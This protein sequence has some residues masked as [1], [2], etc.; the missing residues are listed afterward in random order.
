MTGVASAA[1]ALLLMASPCATQDE[2]Q[3]RSDCRLDAL[4]YCKAAILSG[5]RSVIIAC[6]LE[7]KPKLQPNCRRH[8][9]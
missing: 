8:L 9:W 3:I 1:A 5:D 2:Q 4:R 6:M 7:N